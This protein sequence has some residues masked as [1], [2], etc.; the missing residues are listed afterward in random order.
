MDNWPKNEVLLFSDDPNWCKEHLPKATIV[1]H[2]EWVDLQMMR[3][4]SSHVI[5]NS[6]FAWWGAYGSQDVTY[7]MPWIMGL[8]LNIFELEWKSVPRR[9]NI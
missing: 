3:L 6:T 9:K 7:P 4:C 2:E 1:H 8:D 5:S